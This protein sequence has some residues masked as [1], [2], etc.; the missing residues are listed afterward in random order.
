M[1]FHEVLAK[2]GFSQLEDLG[3]FA[4]EKENFLGKEMFFTGNIRNNAFFNTPEFIVEDVKEA[5]PEDIIT[6]LEKHP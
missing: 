5:Q 4:D 1:L 2:L 3:K 6:E